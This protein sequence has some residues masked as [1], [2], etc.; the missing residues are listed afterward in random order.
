MKNRIVIDQNLCN[1]CEK[2]LKVC[3]NSIL[4]LINGKVHVVNEKR[5]DTNGRC[6]EFCPNHAIS[7]QPK[8]KTYCEG[9][10]CFC[11]MDSELFNWPVQITSVSCQ[12]RYLEGS[13][14][15]IAADCSAYAYANF[16]QDFICDHTVLIACPKN[17]LTNHLFEKCQMLFQNV[18]FESIEVI[19]MNAPCCKDLLEIVRRAAKGSGKNY[20]VYERIISPDGEVFE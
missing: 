12:N 9:D 14:L 11:G 3:S 16:H 19:A 7:L 2:C 18:N 1:G 17:D 13:K 6:I 10:D 20:T 15:L 5:C 8:R 4:Q